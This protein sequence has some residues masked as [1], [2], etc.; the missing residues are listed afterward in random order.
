MT[1]VTGVCDRREI[2]MRRRRRTV[3]A[4]V[5]NRLTGNYRAHKVERFSQVELRLASNPYRCRHRKTICAFCYAGWRLE[6]LFLEAL[7]WEHEY[8]DE[9][10]A[11]LDDSA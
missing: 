11:P 4:L 2:G 1:H 7:P 9:S 5:D 8:S 3:D 10:S 6:Y